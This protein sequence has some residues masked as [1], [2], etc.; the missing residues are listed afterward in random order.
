MICSVLQTST[1]VSTL[2]TANKSKKKDAA[3]KKTWRKIGKTTK[4]TSGIF[5]VLIFIWK[6]PL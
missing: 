2:L 5:L 3:E 6:K 4:K 1:G